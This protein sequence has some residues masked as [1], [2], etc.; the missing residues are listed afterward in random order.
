MP[1]NPDDRVSKQPLGSIRPLPSDPADLEPVDSLPSL[2][3]GGDGEGGLTSLAQSA[4]EKQ[5]KSAR[6]TMIAVGVITIL[7]N[8]LAFFL[9][10]SQMDDMIR[11]AGLNPANLP[12]QVQL[13]LAIRYGTTAAFVLLGA[14]FVV[15]GMFVRQH[16]V[17]CTVTGLVLFVLG[18]LISGVLDPM[19]LLAGIIFKIIIIVAL[20]KAVQAAIAYQRE[21]AQS[22]A[23]FE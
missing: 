7:F 8:T 11:V 15:L 14:I 16:P 5:L 4:R 13:E 6:S 17:P 20:A 18:W 1:A 2:A 22:E 3:R 19:N 10:K 23:E 21:Q 9:I 12:P